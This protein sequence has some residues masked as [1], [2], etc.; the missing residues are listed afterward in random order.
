MDAQTRKHLFFYLPI[1]IAKPKNYLI[2]TVIVLGKSI[3]NMYF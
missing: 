2:T 1:H 3:T